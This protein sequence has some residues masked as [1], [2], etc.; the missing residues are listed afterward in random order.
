MSHLS[1][2]NE[3]DYI[4]FDEENDKKYFDFNEAKNKI[5]KL[6]NNREGKYTDVAIKLTIYSYYCID[7]KFIDLPGIT[8]TCKIFSQFLL[9]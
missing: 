2:N 7:M 8:N 9:I 4:I 6:M 1:K 3:N 5:E